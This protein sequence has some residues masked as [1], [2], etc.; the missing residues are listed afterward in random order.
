MKAVFAEGLGI[1]HY[2][3]NP[4]F[5][6]S[7]SDSWRFYQMAQHESFTAE[8]IAELNTGFRTKAKRVEEP[9]LDWPKVQKRMVTGTYPY[10]TALGR[11]EQGWTHDEIE[12]EGRIKT[13]LEAGHPLPLPRVIAP[14]NSFGIT[15]SLGGSL[16]KRHTFICCV[17]CV[18][19]LAT[20]SHAQAVP[21]ATSTSQIQIGAAGT[22]INSDYSKNQKGFS[23]YGDFDFFHNVGIEGDIHFA[24][25]T[26][27]DISENSYLLGPRYSL[28]YKRFHPY[29]KALFG[30][31][32]FGFQQGYFPSA[33]TST[34]GQVA[35]G[36][37]LDFKASRHINVR[38]FDVEFQRWPNFPPNGLSPIVYN[39]GVAYVLR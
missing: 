4:H 32:R 36:G 6:C 39:F 1:I 25:I 26:P 29:A 18:L 20:W 24:L 3:Y 31:G 15:N 10:K 7:Q 5:R 17:A 11:V 16:L 14:Q 13:G 38:A 35:L 21:T 28:H 2:P 8:Y 12:T 33:S 30:I 9:G 23:I 27:A 37:G 22:F 34:Y 19:S